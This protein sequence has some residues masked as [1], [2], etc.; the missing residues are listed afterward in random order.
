VGQL[1]SK[2]K[3]AD[4]NRDCV[5]INDVGDG[6]ADAL[7]KCA[8]PVSKMRTKSNG[9]TGSRQTSLQLIWSSQ[10]R[11]R[12]FPEIVELTIRPS[13]DA[14][15]TLAFP[16]SSFSRATSNFVALPIRQPL[17]YQEEAKAHSDSPFPSESC[18]RVRVE[19]PSRVTLAE[20]AET[21]SFSQQS[22]SVSSSDSFVRMSRSGPVDR[23]A[24]ILE[25]ITRHEREAAKYR[26]SQ[27]R[28]MDIIVERVEC[29]E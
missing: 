22:S 19:V 25:K 6:S 13:A 16:T 3:L 18:L 15:F 17:H 5:A 27:E 26:E 4:C 1:R 23:V 14:F 11:H 20:V 7:S 24:P 2:E 29:A 8:S 10:S 21:D 9:L 28:A 12:F